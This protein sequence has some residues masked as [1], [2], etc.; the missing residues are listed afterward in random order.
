MQTAQNSKAPAQRLADRAAEWLVLAA[1]GAGVLTFVIWFFVIGQTALFALTLAVTAVVI[2][3]PDALGLATPTAV[4]VG[5]GIG[6][7]NGILI[8][9][10]TALEQTSKIQAII[11][12]KTGTL[13]EGKPAVTD[14]VVFAG[15][16]WQPYPLSRSAW[17]NSRNTP[18]VAGKIPQPRSTTCWPNT[19]IG[20]SRI[21]SRP[22]KAS[23]RDMPT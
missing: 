22:W 15:N 18:I 11:F 1:V 19:W 21:T 6:A 20:S 3:C 8:K 23:G 17:R 14:T 7:R 10:A 9:N 16:L 2:A 4:A 12:D 5:T 13:T